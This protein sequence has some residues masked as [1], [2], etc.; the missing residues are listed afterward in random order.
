MIS[1]A[2][3]EKLLDELNHLALILEGRGEREWNYDYV[4]SMIKRAREEDARDEN[5][6]DN[7]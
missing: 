5:A 6:C 2:T 7:S 1:K 3:L 4:K